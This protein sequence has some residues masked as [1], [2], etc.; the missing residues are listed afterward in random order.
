[1]SRRIG[2]TDIKSVKGIGYAPGSM[3]GCKP[4]A[5]V[6]DGSTP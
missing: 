1:M 5:F 6:L 3:A 2:T 4:V